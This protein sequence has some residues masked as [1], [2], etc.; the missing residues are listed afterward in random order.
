MNSPMNPP[1]VTTKT[2]DCLGSGIFL[3]FSY[4]FFGKSSSAISVRNASPLSITSCHLSPSFGLYNLSPI[5]AAFAAFLNA[6]RG[7]P[8]KTPPPFSRKRASYLRLLFSSEC[9]WFCLIEIYPQVYRVRFKSL[10]QT[11]SNR[12]SLSLRPIFWAC[13]MPLGVNSPP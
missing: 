6:V 11:K 10:T 9:L 5:P 4:F 3:P 12:S 2:F 13:S 1:W 8:S 7:Y